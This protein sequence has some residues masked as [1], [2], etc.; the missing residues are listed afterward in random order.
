MARR[1]K[2][3]SK[4]EISIALDEQ[5][6]LIK[7]EVNSLFPEIKLYLD[8]D[9]IFDFGRFCQKINLLL[10]QHNIKRASG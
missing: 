2:K 7:N 4:E 1:N 3:V 10:K 9:E 5:R 8:K 6:D